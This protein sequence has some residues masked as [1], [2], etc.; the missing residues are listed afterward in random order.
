MLEMMTKTA[1]NI[2]QDDDRPWEQ[3]HLLQLMTKTD[4]I[5]ERDDRCEFNH[6]LE[7]VTKTEA[8]QERDDSG[9]PSFGVETRFY[10]D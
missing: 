2:E 3:S 10:K 4:T 5:S 1:H 7:L 8:Q 9:D 6:L